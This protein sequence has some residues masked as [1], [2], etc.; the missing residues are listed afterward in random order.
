MASGAVQYAFTGDTYSTPIG[1][2]T[3]GEWGDNASPITIEGI[4]G[5]GVIVA[6]PTQAEATLEVAPVD[7]NGLLDKILR[8]AGTY[9][10]GY[11]AGEPPAFKLHLGDDA[12]GIYAATWQVASA[13][14]NFAVGDVLKVSYKLIASGKPSR[15]INSNEYTVAQTPFVWHDGSLQLHS[16]DAEVVPCQLSLDNGLKAYH[17]LNSKTAGSRRWNDGCDSGSEVI[18]CNLT[19]RENPGHA[20]D[21]DEL[22]E[23]DIVLTAVSLATTPLTATFTLSNAKPTVQNTRLVAATAVREWTVTYNADPS[24][25]ALT[26]SVE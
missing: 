23:A 19:L 22:E 10:G 12:S 17:T 6:G 7:N 4:G 5:A 26:I 16:D 20:L 13:T 8:S 25:G 21:A 24:S 11:P 1:I 3:G 18:T 14:I 9:Y 2:I 15:G